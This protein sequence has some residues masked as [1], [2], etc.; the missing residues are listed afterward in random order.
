VISQFEHLVVRLPAKGYGT[1]EF[2]MS[3]E[4]RNLL[5]SS[6]REAMKTYLDSLEQQTG[7]DLQPISPGELADRQATRMMR[8]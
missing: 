6:G 1:V 4:R 8:T 7:Q 2:D 3:E 5:V